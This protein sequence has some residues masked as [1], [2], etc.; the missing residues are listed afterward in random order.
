[1]MQRTLL[2]VLAHPDDESF[3]PGGTLAK[4][5]AE[6]VD[7]HICIA[8]DGVAGSV[9]DGY[10]EA[11]ADLAA[12]RAGEL[13]EAVSIL[14]AS[15]HHFDYRDSGMRGDPANQH[16]DAFINADK[17]EATGRIVRLIRQLK[18]QVIIT[19]DQTGGYFHPDHIRCYE[20]TTAAFHAAA[21]PSQYPDQG[22]AP[23][24]PQLLYY[25]ALPR[26]R[27]KLFSWLLRLR[28]ENPAAVGRNQDI[29]L[30]QLGYPRQD[31]HATIDFTPYWETKMRA[32]AAHASQGGNGLNGLLPVWLQKRLLA[33]DTFIRAYPP[34]PN[35]FRD[36]DLFNGY[37]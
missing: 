29:D 35:G 2:A 9:E 4:Y 7:V 36:D 1:M 18:P 30:T 8:T 12:V 27:L 20:I 26:W 6:G 17:E 32:S 10:E 28:G 16:P 22:P 37:Y 31:L 19:N 33:T 15:L 24:Q 21:D 11:A 34:E 14:G 3:G 5:A 23:H 25:T 13:Q